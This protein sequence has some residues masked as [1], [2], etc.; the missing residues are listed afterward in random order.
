MAEKGFKR[1]LTAILSADVVGYSRLMEDNEDATIQTLN[2]CRNSMS[3][4]VQQHRGRVVDTTG[5]NLMAEFSSVVDAVKCAVETQKEMS[6]RNA[7]LP[8]SRRML[9][10]IGVNL[11]DIVEEEDRIYGD[12]VN[13]AARLE[14]LAEAGGICISRTAYDQVKKKLELGYEYLGEHSVKNITEP[15]RVYR[16][17]MEPEAVGKVIGEKTAVAKKWRSAAVAAAALLIVA[18]IGFSVWTV[19]L[20]QSKK[21]EAASIDNMAY[22]LPDKPSIAVMPFVNLS[23]DS[24]QEFLANSIS[25]NLIASLSQLPKVFVI[26]RGSTFTYKGKSVKVKQVSEELGVQY[27]VEGSVQQSGNRIRITAQLIDALKGY[28]VWGHRYD[29]AYEDIFALQDD[30]T[31]N[32]LKAIQL[33]VPKVFSAGLGRGTNNLEAYL[34]F[35][36]GYDHFNMSLQEPFELDQRELKMARRLFEDAIESDPEYAKAYVMVGYT[37][38]YEVIY[39]ISTSPEK[40]INKASELANKSLTLNPDLPGGHSLLA[41]IFLII[42]KHSQAI[43]ESKRTL[44]LNPSTADLGV[45]GWV[46]LNSGLFEEAIAAYEDLLRLDPY[47]PLGVYDPFANACFLIGKYDRPI[48]FLEVAAKRLPDSEYVLGPLAMA[49]SLSGRK[50]EAQQILEKYCNIFPFTI[51]VLDFYINTLPFKNQSDKDRLRALIIESGTVCDMPSPDT[52]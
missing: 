6:E 27:V 29:K 8:E 51:D 20:Y 28:H 24:E 52:K 44:G 4:L 35:L 30:I 16:V 40:H 39:G 43:A 3:N 2:T 38:I 46:F 11:G 12:G 42:G 7:E 48:P 5:D 49:Y 18:T 33:E 34:K 47:P 1:K 17:L 41:N 14:G 19:Y 45:V 22:P 13:I 9:F 37:Y 15:V 25:E 21:V 50:E 26:A 10:R 36:Q 32:I 23:G 31:L